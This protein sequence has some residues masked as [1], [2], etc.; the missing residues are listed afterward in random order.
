MATLE[1]LQGL[2]TDSDLQAKVESSIVIAVQGVLDGTPTAD[3]Q[4]YAAAVFANTRS[5][6]L[7]ALKSVLAVNSA[8]TVAAIQGATDTAINSNVAAVIDTLSV[9]YNAA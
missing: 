1:E 4:K 9:A 3:E 2:F 7:K 8:S 5:E 6:A